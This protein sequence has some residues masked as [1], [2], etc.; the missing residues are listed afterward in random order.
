MEN[1]N[2]NLNKASE[3]DKKIDKM[4]VD[5]SDSEKCKIIAKKLTEYIKDN[6]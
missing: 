6:K 2:K 1:K 4:R 3:T 5:L